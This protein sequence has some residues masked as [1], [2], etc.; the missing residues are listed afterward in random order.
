MFSNEKNWIRNGKYEDIF[1]D[2]W[3]STIFY[4]HLPSKQSVN[5]SVGYFIETF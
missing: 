4:V 1:R 2:E 3:K 5:M